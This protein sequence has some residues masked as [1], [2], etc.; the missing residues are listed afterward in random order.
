MSRL[1]VVILAG[2]RGER[3]GGVL[4]A[5]LRLGAR[6]LLNHVASR[7]PNDALLLVAHGGHDAAGVAMP[8]GAI[9][10]ADPVPSI[11]PLG[12]LVAAIDGI[13]RAGFSIDLIQTVSVD[14]PFLP[15]D[16]STRLA[17]ALPADRL[18]I[19]PQF[20]GQIAPTHG[21]WRLEALSTH[22]ALTAGLPIGP[23]RLADLLGAAHLDWPDEGSGD[24]FASINTLADLIAA[25][26]RR[27][28][29]EALAKGK[30][31]L[32]KAGQTR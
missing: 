10:L 25:S 18:A 5:N 11:G 32:G 6:P 28:A 12:G 1:A 29:E 16:L 13:K 24:P 7:L 22:P 20:G 27:N 14:S 19:V 9:A 17:E 23:R 3:L 4:K 30:F 21:L 2:G 15:R 8:E 26:R 31:G